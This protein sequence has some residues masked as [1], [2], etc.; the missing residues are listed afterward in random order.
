MI[1]SKIHS[2]LITVNT[3][4]SHYKRIFQLFKGFNTPSFSLEGKKSSKL[5]QFFDYLYV[6]FL[7]KIMPSH[8]HLFCFDTKNRREFK[9]YIGCSLSDPHT[10][11]EL[12]TLWG[13]N[14]IL[15]HDKYLFKVICEYHNLPV[16]LHFGKI[17][18]GKRNINQNDLRQLMKE[19][20]LESVVLKPKLGAWGAGIHF[21]SRDE[22]HKLEDLMSSQEG[23]YIIEENL[24][25]HSEMDK[26]NPHSVNSIRIISFL[27]TDGTVEFLGAMLRTSASTLSVDNFTMGGIVI[28][29]EMSTGKLKKEGFVQFFYSPQINEM[30]TTLSYKSIN[31]VFE[32]LRAKNLLQPGKILLRHPITQTEFHHFQLPYWDELKKIAIKAQK[33]FHHIKSIG[34]DIAIT[35]E[36]P[37][38]I[39]SNPDWGTI[40]FQAANGGLLT[41]EN[42]KLFNQYGIS[43]YK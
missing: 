13:G 12:K 42:R 7:L 43:F 9:K 27:C 24:R 19:N 1:R 8:Y 34:W 11:R 41:A 6:F 20:N 37:V 25:Q 40:G 38:I 2:A 5:T 4:I 36:G 17:Q 14:K 39:E 3:N 10:I 18:D 22:L 30:K 15:I 35:Q 29:I 31:Q 32:T 21:I 28:G 33:I 23:D 26:I 16:P